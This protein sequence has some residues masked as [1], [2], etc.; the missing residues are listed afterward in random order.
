LATKRSRAAGEKREVATSQPQDITTSLVVTREPPDGMFVRSSLK[1]QEPIF[2][3]LVLQGTGV[4]DISEYGFVKVDE[5]VDDQSKPLKLLKPIETSKFRQQL[6]EQFVELDRMFLDQ[7][8]ELTIDLILEK[9]SDD[10]KSLSLT[11]SLQIKRQQSVSVTNILEHLGK[12]LSAPGLD[13][14]GQLVVSAA[15]PEDA[16]NPENALV[17][18]FAG[19]PDRI[20]ELVLLRGD[21]TQFS[22]GGMSSESRRARAVLW[23]GERVPQDAKLQIVLA[24]EPK[25]DTVRVQFTNVPIHDRAPDSPTATPRF[26]D[27]AF[28]GDV[29]ETSSEP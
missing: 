10:A 7:P 2:A 28:Q 29:E 17:I 9:P 23:G 11:G 12:P 27:G 5:V 21:G 18:E 20:Q 3:T 16:E 8:D 24:G 14:V 25:T 13:R 1:R 6:E 26:G 22:R 4:A 15:K 19:D